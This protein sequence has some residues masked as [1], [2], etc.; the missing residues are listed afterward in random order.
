M[1]NAAE[2]RAQTAQVSRN[3]AASILHMS[4][5]GCR[6]PATPDRIAITAHSVCGKFDH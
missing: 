4:T 2:I 5:A 1:S 3:T 6:Y